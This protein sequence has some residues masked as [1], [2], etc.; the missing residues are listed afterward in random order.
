M[1]RQSGRLRG[2]EADAAGG[3]NVNPPPAP[4][5]WQEMFAAMEAQ[6]RGTQ[7]ELRAVRQQAASPVPEVEIRQ[8]EVPMHAPAPVVREGRIEPLYERFRK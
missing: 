1:A 7:A 4:A 3:Q 6:L 2:Q 5:N 8:G